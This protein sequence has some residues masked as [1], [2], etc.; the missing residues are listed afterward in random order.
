MGKNIEKTIS[1]SIDLPDHLT[2]YEK[3]ALNSLAT[4]LRKKLGDKLL[5]IT[6]FGSKARGD[7]DA[8]SDIDV[9]IVVRN[10]SDLHQQ[11]R[12]IIELA[13]EI[14]LRYNVVLSPLIMDISEY[15]WN[16]RLKMPLIHFI[17]R[18]GVVL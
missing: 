1:T 6:L 7:F 2:D 3:V 10:D 11:E 12:V 15:Q 16:Q 13:S 17:E 9:F 8:E 14:S 5:F 4:E 18:Q